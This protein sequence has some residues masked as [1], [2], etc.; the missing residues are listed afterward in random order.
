MLKMKTPTIIL[1]LSAL[2][3]LVVLASI[4]YQNEYPKYEQGD[5]EN[6]KLVIMGEVEQTERLI[7][8][9]DYNKDG[10]ITSSDYVMIKK[11]RIEHE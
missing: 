4:I 6:I 3:S 8:V 5:L 1:W 7:S 10:A 11:E 2:L 9:Y